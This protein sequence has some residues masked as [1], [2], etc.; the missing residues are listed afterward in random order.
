MSLADPSREKAGFAYRTVAGRR[1]ASDEEAPDEL[2]YRSRESV[3]RQMLTQSHTLGSMQIF[4]QVLEA[5]Q[6]RF[7]EAAVGY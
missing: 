3:P 4:P 1:A 6:A 5:R 2:S 7:T